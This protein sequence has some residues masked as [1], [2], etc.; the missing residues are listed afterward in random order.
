MSARSMMAPGRRCALADG[1]SS[2]AALRRV[3]LQRWA[4]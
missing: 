2:H 1:M 4:P 3:A